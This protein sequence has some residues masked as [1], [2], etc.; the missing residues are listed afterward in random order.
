MKKKK[1]K[2][3]KIRQMAKKIR[4]MANDFP[5]IMAND[6]PKTLSKTT[7]VPKTS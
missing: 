7:G 3:K 4:I 6:F 5:K 1:K 2:K